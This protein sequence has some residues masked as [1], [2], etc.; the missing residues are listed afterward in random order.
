MECK[1][2]KFDYDEKYDSLFLFCEEDYEYDTSLELGADFIID[3]SK[4]GFPI[5]FELFNASNL[6]NV[7]KSDF[8]NIKSLNIKSK[9]TEK[10]IQV[11]IK[12]LIVKMNQPI[13]VAVDRVI[14]NVNNIPEH[15]SELALI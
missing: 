11:N 4:D 3:F 15:C 5:A 9:I 7:K 10:E 1:K 14:S 2:L 6:F 13:N 12:I 8:N